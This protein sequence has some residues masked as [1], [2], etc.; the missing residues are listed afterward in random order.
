MRLKPLPKGDPRQ[1]LWPCLRL[2]IHY[3]L[4]SFVESYRCLKS[5][6]CSG[7][8]WTLAKGDRAHL[9]MYLA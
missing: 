2:R 5:V 7:A 6:T 8:L 3:L 9:T 4:R 1:Y